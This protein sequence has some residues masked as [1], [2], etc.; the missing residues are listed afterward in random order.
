MR[1]TYEEMKVADELVLGETDELIETDA[2][3][4]E[5]EPAVVEPENEPISHVGVVSGCKKLNVRSEASI[6]G[7]VVCII[8]ENDAVVI[9]VKASVDGWYKVYTE[10]GVEGYCMAQYIMIKA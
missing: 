6:K 7:N 2:V 4:V 9:D 8:A 1:R 5:E 3:E 10:A